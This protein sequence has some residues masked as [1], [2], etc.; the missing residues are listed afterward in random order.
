MLWQSKAE[1][2]VRESLKRAKDIAEQSRK[3]AM[4]NRLK[5]YRDDWRQLLDDELAREFTKENYKGLLLTLDY[6]Q[7]ILKKVINEISLVYKRPPE[8]MFE[9][10]VE[11]YEEI[12][13]R[14][15]LDVFMKKI[16]KYMNL[17][18]DVLIYVPWDYEAEDIAKLKIITPD[19]CSVVQNE[20]DPET[21]DALWYDIDWYDSPTKVK[22]KWYVFWSKE[23]HF[24]FSEAG[25]VKAP[26]EDNQDMVNPYGE[27]PFVIIHRDQIDGQFWNDTGGNDLIN[28]CLWNG[29]KKTLKN[30]YFKHAS[31]KQPYAI[32]AKMKM[33]PEVRSDPSTIWQLEG[34]GEIG[35]LDLTAAFNEFDKTMLKDVNDFLSTYNLSVDMFAISPAEASGRA[36]KIRNQGLIDLR[37]DQIEVFRIAEQDLFKIITMVHNFHTTG[38]KI[39]NKAKLETDFPEPEMYTDPMEKLRKDKAEMEG[40]IISP[41][42][43]YMRYNPDCK[44]EEDGEE[45][46]RE[47]LKKVA[48]IKNE[49][50]GL[51]LGEVAVK[52]KKKS[53][54]ITADKESKQ[55]AKDKK[56]DKKQ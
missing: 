12:L 20:D 32:G 38:K 56:Q 4:K 7:N 17:L 33:P 14:L 46:L 26:A 43:F 11:M 35:T 42:T 39:N 50:F 2:V 9:P 15:N 36:L 30:Y 5:I 23:K 54:E 55:E 1:Q 41:G 6:S 31:F 3:D 34:S 48:D 18:N 22:E 27:L 10:M 25:E 16:N 44:N 49:G 40:G 28:G 37:E 29:K 45:K 8:R 13:S 21:I 19:C 24:Y 53:P 47:N 52:E 51:Y